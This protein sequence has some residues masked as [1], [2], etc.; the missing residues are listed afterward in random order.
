MFLLIHKL[1]KKPEAVRQRIAFL[2][3][4]IGTGII[5]LFWLVALFAGG[6]SQGGTGEKTQ[7]SKAG[8]FSMLSDAVG[9]L[10]SET[11]ATFSGIQ[12]AWSGKETVYPA[13][14]RE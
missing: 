11:R 12:K 13:N 14:A 8:P 9:G 1:Q 3:A 7:P 10:V 5:V 2:S 4:V 6:L